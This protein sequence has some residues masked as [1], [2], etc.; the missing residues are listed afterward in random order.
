MPTM[1]KPRPP[2]GARIGDGEAK[3][4]QQPE[5]R[6]PRRPAAV[7]EW[8]RSVADETPPRHADR[9][10]RIA[11]RRDRDRAAAHGG[12]VD[13]APV[14]HGAFDDEAEQHDGAEP[15]GCAGGPGEREAAR[16]RG[17][18]WP[19]AGSAIRLSSA[20]MATG[21]HN[22]PAAPPRGGQ[23]AAERGAGKAPQAEGAMEGRH[24]RPAPALLDMPAWPF[25]PRRARRSKAPPR[26]PGR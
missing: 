19:R 16:R 22:C 4:E 12:Q 9:K 15:E 14:R 25:M 7:P 1:A 18:P 21:I 13:R 17:W 3:A 24:D 2:N 10:G 20:A 5:R 26:K 11:G 8:Q 23:Q 6:P